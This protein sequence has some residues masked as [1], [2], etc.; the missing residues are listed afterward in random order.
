MRKRSA[1]CL[2]W[3]HSR[4]NS[5]Q[6]IPLYAC[7]L[8]LGLCAAG[9][10]LFPTVRHGQRLH[11]PF[12]QLKRVAVLPFYNQSDEPTLNQVEVAQ[13]YYAALQA[14]PGFEVLPVGGVQLE[15]EKYSLIY[16][17]PEAGHEYQEFAQ[18]IGVDAVVVGT[19]TDFSPYYPP[20]MAMTTHW[21]A[22][23]PGF[24]P[25]PPGYGLP[26]GTDA[27]KDIPQHVVLETE[28]ELASQQLATQT[29]DV[30]RLPEPVSFTE[31]LGPVS[32][33]L[34]PLQAL[35]PDWP[36]PAG[37]IPDQPSPVR[38]IAE[39]QS[40]PVLTHTRIYN[41]NDRTF[42]ERLEKHVATADD[43]RTGGWQGYLTRS[44]D[45]IRFCCHLHITEMLELR[46]GV[47]QS[48][49]ILRWPI[50]RYTSQ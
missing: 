22:A 40:E 41:G 10:S 8:L 25:I 14:I 4:P 35:P 17:E 19:V 33:D 32:P 6:R 7:A 28:F 47:D 26:W 46:G 1:E 23:N 49:L 36:D 12:P 11:N 38:P 29:P 30:R 44:N 20:R 2:I 16:G 43:A 34:P 37:L 27:E 9:C 42:T 3:L 5:P 50:S 18:A 13:A 48:D 31:E 39:P 21:Y 45:F 24:Y 15:W